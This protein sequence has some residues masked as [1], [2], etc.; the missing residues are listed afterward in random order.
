MSRLYDTAAWKRLRKQQ[1]RA[2]P[3]CEDC[4]QF[5]IV[6][7]ATDVDHVR[8]LKD[9]GEPLDPENLAS[10]CHPCHSLKT[11]HVDGGFGNQRKASAPIKGC[12]VNGMPLDPAHPWHKKT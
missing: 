12:D 11:A 8:A 7:P 4:L 2:H 3:L 6:R 9:G 5:G 1:L 10:R